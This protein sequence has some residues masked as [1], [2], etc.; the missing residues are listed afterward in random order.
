MCLQVLLATL[1]LGS[2]PA[3]PGAQPSTSPRAMDGGGE[4][5]APRAAAPRLSAHPERPFIEQASNGGQHLSFE[6]V[7]HGD[8]DVALKL[9]KLELDVRDE[10]G[11]LA[12]SRRLEGNG[13][14]PGLSILPKT[15][16]PAKGTLYLFNP[17]HSFT[18]GLELSTLHYRLTFDTADEREVR[19][20]LTVHPRRFVQATRL[21]LPLRGRM[22]VHS[23]HDFLA[24]HR[25]LDLG[26]PVLGMLG[27]RSNGGRYALDLC[28]TDEAGAMFRGEGRRNEDWYG[29]GAPVYAPAAG[30][31]V[32]SVDGVPD[33][34]LGGASFKPDL[35]AVRKDP[36]SLAGNVVVIDHGK[37]EYSLLAH[38][39]QNTVTVKPGDTVR[40][41]QLLGQVGMSG[42]AY[43]P[44]VHYELR[45]GRAST[46]DTA[47]VEGLPA[48]FSDFTRVLGRGRE[49][50]ALGAVDSGE[51]VE[52]RAVNR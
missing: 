50:V 46:W 20:E 36:M 32:V 42:D 4:A 38:L 13:F 9:V 45:D 23:G 8:A 51:R 44:H 10:D 22:F 39:R 21:T 49:R 26:H 34:L 40:A 48:R 27:V 7:I 6:L 15:E 17:F 1:L 16:V 33:N 28:P 37:G 5:P 29:W 35:D 47:G 41:G 2:A 52:A 30:T 24:H 31:V 19:A 25:R 18:R 3:A 12:W 11:Q 14:S 43:I